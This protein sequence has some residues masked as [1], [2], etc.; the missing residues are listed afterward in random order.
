VLRVSKWLPWR[1]YGCD[2][3]PRGK[4]MTVAL[5]VHIALRCLSLVEDHNPLSLVF[6]GALVHCTVCDVDMPQHDVV[7]H[8]KGTAS[9]WWVTAHRRRRHE[10]LPVDVAALG[11]GHGGWQPAEETHLQGF[12]R[13][14]ANCRMPRGLVLLDDIH[15]NQGCHR[16]YCELCRAVLM[17][18][19]V[20]ASCI[21]LRHVAGAAHRHCMAH[22]PITIDWRSPPPCGT[23]FLP[24][25]TT[26]TKHVVEKVRRNLR[27]RTLCNEAR[28]LSDDILF[29]AP[30]VYVI[31]YITE[32][33]QAGMAWSNYGS[34]HID[35]VVPVA[36]FDCADPL[37][38]LVMCHYTNLQ[39]LWGHQNLA[40]GTLIDMA[41]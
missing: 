15:D 25:C 20:S 33:F 18:H 12:R 36:A 40:K 1:F 14:V 31:E 28:K 13:Y 26:A 8:L 35:H 38:C 22:A 21:V 9:P 30:L 37:Q 41:R 23:V 34:W 16:I 5:E 19:T 32:R 27:A 4:Q 7:A 29:G 11:S 6:R 24:C 17:D 39:P 2:G 10:T 3:K